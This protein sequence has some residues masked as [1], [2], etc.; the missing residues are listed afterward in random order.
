MRA[1]LPT[2]NEI[3]EELA[4][5]AALQIDK[6]APVF[7]FFG[8]SARLLANGNIEFTISAL[9]TPPPSSAIFEVTKTTPPTT[10]WSMQVATYDYRGTRMGSLYP[11]VQW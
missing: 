4:D 5:K 8:G 2:P 9:P 6:L 1:R 11:G 7:S 10:V 3:L